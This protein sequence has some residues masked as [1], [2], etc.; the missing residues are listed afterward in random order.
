MILLPAAYS[1]PPF[2]LIATEMSFRESLGLAL[3]GGL[4]SLLLATVSGAIAYLTARANFGRELQRIRAQIAAEKEAEQQDKIAALK[5]QY[6]A[7]LNYYART[8]SRRFGALKAKYSSSEEQR[9]RNWFKQIKDHVTGDKRMKDYGVWCCYEGTFSVSTLYFTFS[10]FQCAREVVA[11]APFREARPHF[12]EQLTAQLEKIRRS[13][14]WNG[15]EDGIWDTLQEVIGETFTEKGTE[16]GSRMTYA[17]MCQEQDSGDAFRRAPYLRPLDFF[18][19][20]LAPDRADI[21]G[22]A[23]AEL[24]QFLNTHDPQSTEPMPKLPAT[25]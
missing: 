5:Q 11:N 10:Y 9:V 19:G 24:V 15:G 18:W 12:S 17:Q 8:L 6:L 1:A 2:F 23:L 22:Q 7:P 4:L 16:K 20:Q 14:W 25:A 21:I 13:F 3:V